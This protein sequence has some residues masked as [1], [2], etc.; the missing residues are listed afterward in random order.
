MAIKEVVDL[1]DI[2]SR[3]L[4]SPECMKLQ[5]ERVLVRIR[6]DLD[7][8]L[9]DIQ[10]SPH[11]LAKTMMN[12]VA[13][14]IDSLPDGG[15]IRISTAKRT[16]KEPIRDDDD[17]REGDYVV[18]SLSDNGVGISDADMERI[19]EP[20]YTKNMMGRCGTGL[21]MAV[22]WE[23]MKVHK[24]FIDPW[25][26]EGEGARFDLYFPATRSDPA[27]PEPSPPSSFSWETSASSWWTMWRTSGGSPGKY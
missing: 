18:F 22:V 11:H 14:A 7:A 25:S 5:F 19:F 8:D 26:E 13:N 2:I 21:G 12:L 4:K 17:F 9:P 1:N 3:T 24:G 20:F 6:M 15:E 27:A 23:T 16:M 10:G